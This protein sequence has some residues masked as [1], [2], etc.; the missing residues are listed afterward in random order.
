RLDRATQ[1]S[2]WAQALLGAATVVD[3]VQIDR[4]RLPRWIGER[5][6]R[7]GQRVEPDTLEWMADRVEG[8]LLA[9]F[10]EVQ[11]LGLLYPKGDLDNQDVQHGLLDVLIVE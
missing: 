8:N 6:A 2:K 9:A 4:A 1:S 10:Q 5:L 11:K 7:Q 3:V